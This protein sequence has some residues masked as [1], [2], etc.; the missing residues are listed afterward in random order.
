MN[1]NGGT[2]ST[3]LNR[4]R[5]RYVLIVYLSQ[6]PEMTKFEVPMMSEPNNT[7]VNNSDDGPYDFILFAN[8]Q[9]F[10]CDSY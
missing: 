3:T 5:R 6:L 7:F 10:S 4:I 2:T 9:R 8:R 1:S